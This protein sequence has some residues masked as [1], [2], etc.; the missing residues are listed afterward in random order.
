MLK[1]DKKKMEKIDEAFLGIAKNNITVYGESGELI[2][3]DNAHSC[4]YMEY[5]VRNIK[6]KALLHQF[7]KHCPNIDASAVEFCKKTRSYYVITCHYGLSKIYFPIYQKNVLL[8]FIKLSRYVLEETAKDAEK[9]MEKIC[10]D[11]AIPQADIQNIF[12]N[13]PKIDIK[14]LE[15]IAH[16]MEM[17]I[18]YLWYNEVLSKKDNSLGYLLDDYIHEH[19]SEDLSTATLCNYLCISKSTL[20]KISTSFFNTSIAD[21]VETVRIEEA[22]KLLEDENLPMYLIAERTGFVDS[23]YFSKRF[24]SRIKISPSEYRKTIL[25]QSNKKT[26]RKN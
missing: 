22:K 20:Y 1:L 5:M 14:N 16:I 13:I 25:E 10:K 18:C 21:Y 19:L 26:Q 6:D 11:F 23:N 3:T 17:C 4:P 2:Y 7:S 15:N 9:R 12:D 8:G 24:K